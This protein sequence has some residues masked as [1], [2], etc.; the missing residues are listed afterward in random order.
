MLS[1]ITKLLYNVVSEIK[2]KHKHKN[3]NYL[4]NVLSFVLEEKKNITGKRYVLGPLNI[5][6]MNRF[7]II[8]I[9]IV[10]KSTKNRM[11]LN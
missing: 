9:I 2:I 3:D 4:E 10:T 11:K 6:E 7:I 8:I 5:N 1:Y